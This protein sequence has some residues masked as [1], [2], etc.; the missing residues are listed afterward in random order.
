MSLPTLS[1]AEIE[2]S[3]V[4]NAAAALG[5]TPNRK[6]TGRAVVLRTPRLGDGAPMWRIAKDSAV[7]DVNSSYAYLMWCR[8]FAGTSVVA[9]SDGRV[10]GYVIGFVRPQAPDTV[11]VWQIAVDRAQRGRGIAAELL[12]TLLNSVAAQGVSVL[13]TTIS[14]DNIAS[15]AL[16]TSVAKDRDADLTKRPLFDAGVFPDNHAPED[17]YRIAPTARTTEEDHR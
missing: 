11:F 17:L 15:V 12:H 6:D 13:E 10:V 7:L 4:D 16:F 2:R 14:P 1:P 8:D 5:A 9:E 3:R